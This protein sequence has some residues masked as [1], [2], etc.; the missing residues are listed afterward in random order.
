MGTPI[1]IDT[2]NP[3]L[4]STGVNEIMFILRGSDGSIIT[5]QMLTVTSGELIV[6]ALF[7]SYKSSLYSFM[8][9]SGGGW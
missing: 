5:Q 3:D 8:F 9:I 4:L 6:N 1:I 7:K 2:A